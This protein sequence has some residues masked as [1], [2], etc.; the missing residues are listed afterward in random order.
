LD[1]Q[2]GVL[3]QQIF[4]LD[5]RA[6]NSLNLRRTFGFKADLIPQNTTGFEFVMLS[7]SG[8]EDY[9]DVA[10][11]RDPLPGCPARYGDGRM[12][13]EQHILASSSSSLGMDYVGNKA[14]SRNQCQ[15][16]PTMWYASPQFLKRSFGVSM[17]E[18]LREKQKTPKMH[19]TV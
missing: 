19:E 1:G 4:D 2:S 12:F 8:T 18:D 10:Y 3:I 11:H 6:V 17:L 5:Y 13:R 7:L 14:S 9:V 16:R 15:A